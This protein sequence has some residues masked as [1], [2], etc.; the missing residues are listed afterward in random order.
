MLLA[1]ISRVHLCAQAVALGSLRLFSDTHR[2]TP[3]VP[4]RGRI[5]A[6]GHL[7]LPA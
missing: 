1:D 2:T 7:A 5:R 4:D 6:L 3:L